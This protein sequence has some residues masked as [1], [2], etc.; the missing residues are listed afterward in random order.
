MRKTLFLAFLF[1]FAFWST[2]VDQA[3][4]TTQGSNAP[5][6]E[7]KTR[8]TAITTVGRYR[9]LLANILQPILES[10]IPADSETLRP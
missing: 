8:N 3:Q 2:G 4:E 10:K 9:S 7:R 6:L 1:P 5:F